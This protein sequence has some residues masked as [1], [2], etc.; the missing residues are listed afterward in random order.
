M[1]LRLG[2]L[3]TTVT[4]GAFVV[5]RFI[6]AQ[7]I[8]DAPDTFYRNIPMSSE[9]FK[10]LEYFKVSGREY[11][12]FLDDRGIVVGIY[13]NRN[14][15]KTVD[16]LDESVNG[17]LSFIVVYG[18]TSKDFLFEGN[19]EGAFWVDEVGAEYIAVVGATQTR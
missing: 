14:G 13:R 8:K 17:Y 19:V 5:D 7:L 16:V 3:A 10:T 18:E 4:G 15:L 12:E 6:D 9:E 1:L 2:L 11:V